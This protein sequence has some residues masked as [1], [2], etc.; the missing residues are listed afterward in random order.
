DPVD[1]LLRGPNPPPNSIVVET[2]YEDNPYLTDALYQEMTY[3][4]ER[5]PDRYRHVWLGQ[6]QV[7]SESRVFRNWRIE[8]FETP[9]ALEDWERAGLKKRFYFGAD[10]GFS[11]DPTVLVRC[12]ISGRKLY[13]DYEAWA[14]GCEMDHT[15]DLFHLVPEASKWPIIADNSNPQ[16]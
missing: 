11:K 5:D 14:V 1:A 9:Q 3:D 6:Y 4:R 8:A 2:D 16:S 12:W 15:P 13:V 10:W 7:M